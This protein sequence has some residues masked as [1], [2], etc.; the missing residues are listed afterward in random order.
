MTTDQEYVISE[1]LNDLHTG[2]SVTVTDSLVSTA[3]TEAL[4]AN[5]GRVLNEKFGGISIWSGTQAEYDALDPDY[6]ADTLYFI[7]PAS[8]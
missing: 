2:S 6:D 1:A 8:E 5:Q 3:T 4:S 7:K